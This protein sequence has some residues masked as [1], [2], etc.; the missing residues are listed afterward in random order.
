[1]AI[2]PPSPDEGLQNF[3]EFY[4]YILNTIYCQKLKSISLNKFPQA[5]PENLPK[6]LIDRYTPFTPS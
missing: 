1:M 6:N 3:D 2:K 5:Y 4:P